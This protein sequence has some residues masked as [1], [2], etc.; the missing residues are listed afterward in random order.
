[1]SR[2]VPERALDLEALILTA[3][4]H[5]S[6]DGAVC[7]VEAATVV[8]GLHFSDSPSEYCPVLAAFGRRWNDDLDDEGRQKLK[9]FLDDGH[10]HSRLLG[11]GGD[12][13]AERR[14]WMCADWL[15]RVHTP[16]WLDLAGITDASAAL[17][18][19]PALTDSRA[20]ADAKPAI[21]AARDAAWD[22][23]W[24]AARDVLRPTTVELQASALD[25]MEAM[26]TLGSRPRARAC[27]E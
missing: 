25:L 19:L 16:A 26:L 10:G 5:D 6:D 18:A 12:G 20:V 13:L 15:V 23:A 14:A 21:T 9:R 4:S 2:T 1:M 11:T 22:A 17:R 7:F 27:S 3:G 24:D 8:D